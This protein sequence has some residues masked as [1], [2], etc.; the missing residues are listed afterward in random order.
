MSLLALRPGATPS[1]HINKYYAPVYY[2]AQEIEAFGS[3]GSVSLP[4]SGNGPDD[5]GSRGPGCLG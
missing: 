2:D 1:L 4:L 5:L 3:L